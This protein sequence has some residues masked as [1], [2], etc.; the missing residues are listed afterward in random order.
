M[1]LFSKK[2]KNYE[3]KGKPLDFDPLNVQIGDLRPGFFVDY[4]FKTF[5]IT[6]GFEYALKDYSFKALKFDAADE[7]IWVALENAMNT[8]LM[9][10]VGIGVINPELQN[11][12]SNFGKPPATLTYKDV[13]Y[14]LNNQ[15]DGRYRDLLKNAMDWSRLTCWKYV[16]ADGSSTLYALQKG[17]SNFEAIVAKPVGVGEFS[18]FLP[19]I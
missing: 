7:V 14:N 15:G 2:E 17:Q 8:Y 10:T 6:A 11:M 16:A 13:I 9:E 4:N 19:K 5:E 3:P 18:N 12:M 1:G